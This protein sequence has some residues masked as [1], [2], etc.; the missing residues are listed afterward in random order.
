M[1]KYDPAALENVPENVP[2]QE[3]GKQLF[4]YFSGSTHA[5]YQWVDLR[6][7]K[8]VD[9]NLKAFDHVQAKT[10]PAG[11]N[12][13]C[14]KPT[15]DYKKAVSAAIGW[16]DSIYRDLKV[17]TM[18]CINCG[19]HRQIRAHEEDWIGQ[20]WTCDEGWVDSNGEDRTGCVETPKPSAGESSV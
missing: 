17:L 9:E 18:Q 6:S 14:P 8:W 5:E 13:E 10:N 12:R 3:E 2:K 11:P 19:E 4:M 20:D 16:F 7:E 15:E 1:D